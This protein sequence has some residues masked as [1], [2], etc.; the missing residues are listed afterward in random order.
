MLYFF[1]IILIKMDC[2]IHQSLGQFKALGKRVLFKPKNIP[3]W[4]FELLKNPI[5][6]FIGIGSSLSKATLGV[7]R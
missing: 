7:L 4:F 2:E 1:S 3:N 5:K 6:I